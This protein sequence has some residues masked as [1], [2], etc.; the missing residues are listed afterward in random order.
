VTFALLTARLAAQL[1]SEA[2]AEDDLSAG[3]L[4]QYSRERKQLLAPKLL[5][6]RVIQEVIARPRLLAHV[7]E[8]LNGR[9]ATAQT[10][11]GVIA[12]VLPARQALTPGFL[13][14][15]LW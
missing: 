13:R 12:D 15:L 9:P 7:V 2:L 11:I 5:V 14:R 6:Q 10:L 4:E 3:Y 8:R 1:A